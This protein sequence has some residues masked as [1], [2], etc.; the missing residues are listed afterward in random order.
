MEKLPMTETTN[1]LFL[2][3]QTEFFTNTEMVEPTER[4]LPVVSKMT[5]GEVNY[6]EVAKF[7]EYITS[8]V[9]KQAQIIVSINPRQANRKAT[10]RGM[11]DELQGRRTETSSTC[12][13]FIL[14][15]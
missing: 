8:T 2:H 3:G 12:L 11:N 4:P 6:S 9:G 14:G 13:N 15:R 1:T 5:G 10:I 7:T